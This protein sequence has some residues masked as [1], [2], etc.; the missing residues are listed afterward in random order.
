[1]TR[2][3]VDQIIEI[4]EIIEADFSKS[5]A[6]LMAGEQIAGA[7]Y[8]AQSKDNAVAKAAK[9]E[10]VQLKTKDFTSLDKTIADNTN[11]RN[12]VQSELDAVTEYLSKLKKECINHMTRFEELQERRAAEIAGLKGALNVLET[13]TSFVQQS[14]HRSLRDVHKHF[15]A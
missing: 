4:L 14:S 10:E 12:G 7:D 3:A 15:L 8:D 11:D 1:M 5:L 6:E 2:S 13:E 9:Q